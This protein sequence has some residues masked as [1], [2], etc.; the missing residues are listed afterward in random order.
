MLRIGE[1]SK[2][3]K[4]TIKALRY[5]DKLGLLKPAFVDS[6]TLYRYYT[7][8]QIQDVQ[9]IQMF[10]AA[11]LSCEDILEIS[12]NSSDAEHRLHLR[13]RELELLKTDIE[14]Q[15]AQLD[16]LIHKTAPSYTPVVKQIEKCTVYYSRSCI[17]DI[18][19]IKDFIHLTM[20][21]LKRTNPDVG[22]PTPDYCCVIYPQ[23]SY[24]ESNIFI[25]YVQSVNKMGIDTPVIKFKKLEGILAIS[26]T[27]YGSYEH[28]CDA[29]LVAVNYALDNGYEICGNARERYI[30]G[31]WNCDSEDKWKTEIQLPVRACKQAKGTNAI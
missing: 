22:F 20:Q 6:E 31:S 23:E 21:E 18:S 26:V 5:Y 12:K 4:T 13:K 16:R 24:R 9:Q 17:S 8:E 27:H 11:G 7:E 1:F 2:L 19:R 3:T 25:E 15:L 10:R 29:Y 28:L 30:D 14:K